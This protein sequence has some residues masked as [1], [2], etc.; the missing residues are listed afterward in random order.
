VLKPGGRAVLV[1]GDC[2]IRGTFVSNSSAIERLALAAG[3]RS[4]G[5][6]VRDL[7]ENKRY[8]PPPTRKSAGTELQRRM[9]QEVVL[10]FDAA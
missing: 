5:R 2:A 1:V 10:S 8:L 6:V 4:A 3:L 9:R 7:P